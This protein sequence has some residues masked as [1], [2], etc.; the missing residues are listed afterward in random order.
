MIE[1]S[2]EVWWR[3][4]TELVMKKGKHKSTTGISASITPGYREKEVSNNI[5]LFCKIRRVNIY[6][7]ID[8]IPN[9]FPVRRRYGQQVEV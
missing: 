7:I 8:K 1:G 6:N 9:E 5:L 3:R 2:G 4:K